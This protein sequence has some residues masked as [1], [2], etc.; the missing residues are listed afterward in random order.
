MRYGVLLD[1]A[2]KVKHNQPVDLSM[3]Y[4]N[5]IWQGDLNNYVLRSLEHVKSPVKVINITGPEILSAR[6]VAGEFGQLFGTRPVFVNKETPTALLNNSG[7]AYELFGHPK[8]PVKQIIKWI[9]EW[10]AEEKRI[11]DKPTHFEVRDG[12][13]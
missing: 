4:F 11:L 5:V 9:A 10:L 8:T 12:K 2:V 3:G 13:Y 7:Y 1:I 6:D